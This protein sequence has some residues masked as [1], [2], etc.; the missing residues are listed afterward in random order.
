MN[1]KPGKQRTAEHAAKLREQGLTRVSV[2]VPAELADK[3]RSYAEKLRKQ[4]TK[5]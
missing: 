1:A 2:W 5:R 3:L 4:I